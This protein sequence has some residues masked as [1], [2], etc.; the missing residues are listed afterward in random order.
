MVV[1]FRLPN[2]SWF[3]GDSNLVRI[4]PFN[5]P[6][7]Q[8]DSCLGA[9][10]HHLV[11]VL[12]KNQPDSNVHK[13]LR[14]AGFNNTLRHNHIDTIKKQQQLFQTT[15]KI[16][17]HTEIFFAKIQFSKEKTKQVQ[18]ILIE[19]NEDLQKKYWT[20]EGVGRGGSGRLDS[21]HGGIDALSL[22]IKQTPKV[23]NTRIP[24]CGNLQWKRSKNPLGN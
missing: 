19:I 15:K 3:S 4:P 20:L 10:I 6:H 5:Y 11:E 8:I 13:V 2:R 7:V 9:E 12:K 17:P 21:A 1:T 14:S 22:T 23:K 24:Q 16:F 18:Q